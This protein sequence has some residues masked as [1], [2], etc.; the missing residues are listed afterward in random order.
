MRPAA[1]RRISSVAVAG[2][3]AATLVSSSVPAQA[4]DAATGS[5]SLLARIDGDNGD[6]NAAG[7]QVRVVGT[8]TSVQA[9]A[10]SIY[11]NATVSGPVSVAGAQVIVNSDITGSVRA[12]GAMIEL[13]GKIG[14]AVH[15]GGAVV[16]FNAEASDDVA[17]GGASVE[18]GE[19]A[20][21]DGNLTA[22]AASVTIAG[23]ISGETHARGAAVVFNGTAANTVTIGAEEVFIGADANITG[24][25]VV[26]SDN[27]PNIADGATITGQVRLEE[28]SRFWLL[29]TWLWGIVAAAV[30]AVGAVLAALILLL[31]GRGTFEEA[32][33]KA[34]FHPISSGLIGLAV[35]VVLPIVA[36]L[37]MTSVIGLS[38]GFALLAILPFLFVAGHATMAACIGVWIFDR[39]GG[40][41]TV[42]QLVI[43]TIAGAVIIAIVWLIPWVGG[44]VALVAGLVGI[45]A[46]LRAL[47][48]RMRRRDP[49]PV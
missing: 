23:T 37:L 5:D 9:A 1:L 28:P 8:A 24:D 41:R 42:G 22:G 46:Y 27:E 32:L 10:A 21:I 11:I 34:A 3:V 26:Q 33:D 6:V 38:F 39:S 12:G 17:L 45:G 30:M 14:G 16:R 18:V 29:P 19:G 31:I 36:V 2:I 15:A 40:P 49:E 4:P 44:P 35:L 13:Q 7:A 25:L 43:Y 47:S 20:R 48:A